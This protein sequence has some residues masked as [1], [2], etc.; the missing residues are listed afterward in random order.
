MFISLRGSNSGL[1]RAPGFIVLPLGKAERR[2]KKRR[3]EGRKKEEKRNG[4]K[5]GRK[6]GR[7]DKKS[8]EE[9]QEEGILTKI[10]IKINI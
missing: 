6:E 10:K 1:F 2:K 3:R 4:R 9:R 8:L 7:K 5:E